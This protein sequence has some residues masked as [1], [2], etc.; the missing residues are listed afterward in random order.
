MR[1]NAD[2]HAAEVTETARRSRGRPQVRADEETRHLIIEAAA[3]E[4]QANGYAATGIA[5]VAG[6]AGVST[7]T[8]YR[9]IPTKTELFTNVVTERISRFVFEVD[10]DVGDS[11]DAAEALER[12]LVAYGTLT[13]EARTISINRLVLGEC[14]NFPEIAAAFYENAI[15]RTSASMEGL[16]RRFCARGLIALD[17]PSEATGMLRGMMIME[18]QRAAML[19]QRAAPDA[20]TIAVRA[21]RCAR[22]FLNGCAVR[23]QHTEL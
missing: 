1:L 5:D 6:R 3:Q 17:D 9:L 16:L 18:P 22:L 20:E 10:H 15:L 12:M 4:F 7:K 19:G 11:H 14:G 23:A 13:L 21:K 2:T 8:L